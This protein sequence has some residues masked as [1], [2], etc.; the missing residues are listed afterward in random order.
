MPSPWSHPTLLHACSLVKSTAV[1]ADAETDRTRVREIADSTSYVNGLARHWPHGGLADRPEAEESL[2]AGGGKLNE[3]NASHCRR[4]SPVIHSWD[5]RRSITTQP[6]SPRNGLL[7]W[8]FNRT[9]RRGQDRGGRG[10]RPKAARNPRV[11]LTFGDILL[12]PLEHGVGFWGPGKLTS[13]S[14]RSWFSRF[15]RGQGPL[16]K[17]GIEHR[18][19][20]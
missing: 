2:R 4:S 9:N 7:R 14:R 10:S 16:M 11:N 8:L 12:V 18:H 13:C 19:L 20:S 6:R 17:H 1:L 3:A 15:E 5:P